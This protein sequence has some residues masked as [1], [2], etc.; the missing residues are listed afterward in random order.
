M[1]HLREDD[2]WIAYSLPGSNDYL[3]MI[4]EEMKGLSKEPCFMLQGWNKKRDPRIYIKP[5]RTYKNTAWAYEVTDS[6]QLTSS[7]RG[8]YEETIQRTVDAIKANEFEKAVISKVKV[9]QRDE[10]DLFE[11]FTALYKTYPGA[12]TFMYNIP[13]KGTWCGATPEVLITAERDI[14]KTMALAGTL[15]IEGRTLSDVPW[16]AKERHEQGVI[17][18]YVEEACHDL[19][20]DFIKEGPH[21]VKAGTMAHLRSTYKINGS[22]ESINLINRLHPGPAICGRP[23][24]LAK[25]WIDKEEKHDREHYCG[26]LGPWGIEEQKGLYVHLR[27]MRIYKDHYV[28]YL[29][30]GITADSDVTAEWDETELKAQ[31]M[32]SVINSTIHG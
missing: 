32:L 19:A 6:C 15:P 20:L 17:E 7:P 14:V 9:V 24:T 31:T 13:G 12:F 30:G 23:Q 29:G 26:F 3:F 28:L 4:G 27:S 8:D 25:D 22:S 10:D 5:K 18:E 1:I 11:L 21:T 16:T 2:L